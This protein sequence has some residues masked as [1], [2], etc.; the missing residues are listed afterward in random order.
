M[1]DAKKKT[2]NKP[3]INPIHKKS[4]VIKD[5]SI[6][7]LMDM[8]PSREINEDV[9]T[10]AAKNLIKWAEENEGYTLDKWLISRN[11]S[12]GSFDQC[13]LEHQVMRDAHEYVKLIFSAR[14]FDS[15]KDNSMPIG[16]FHKYI[17][18]YSQDY[19]DDE[20]RRAAL[21][22][23]IQAGKLRAIIEIEDAEVEPAPDDK[24]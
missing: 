21:D 14:W 8:Q 22:T 4:R 2:K 12:R 13:F 6:N 1:K 23:Q 24:E 10:F 20:I 3:F 16:L 18:N 19:R 17:G 7:H 5:H 15:T 9:A 11:I